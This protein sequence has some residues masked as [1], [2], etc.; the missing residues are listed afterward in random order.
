MK[1]AHDSVLIGVDGGGT[2]CRVR[3]ADTAFTT[4][5]QSK[6]GPSN[7][8]TDRRAAIGNI[9]D[10]IA[11]AA[12]TAGLSHD[13]IA[14]ARIHLGLAGVMSRDIADDVAQA[15]PYPNIIVTDDRP[16]NL[17][18]ALGGQDG[19]LIAAGTGSFIAAQR[20][21]QSRFVG[22]WG[23]HLSDQASAAWLGRHL[24]EQV[25]LCQ[26]GL[27]QHSDLTRSALARFQDDPNAIV[28]FSGSAKPVDFGALAPLVVDA[29]TAGDPMGQR[30]MQDGLAYLRLGLDR[31]GFQPGDRLCLTGGVGAQ[32]ATLFPQE[33]QIGLIAPAGNALDGA[34]RL[35]A[36]QLGGRP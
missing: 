4:I 24:L 8:T 11:E 36:T 3:I 1:H 2:G 34:I 6:G 13:A 35:A 28:A 21:G 12:T 9:A 10:A 29:M 20:E 17:V 27:A 15:L 14:D 16:T 23:Y 5:A 31:L 18:G 30:L 22:G 26:D 25:L 32:Y 33:V 19:F 7:V